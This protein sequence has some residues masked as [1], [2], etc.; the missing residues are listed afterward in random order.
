M[1]TEALLGRDPGELGYVTEHF[2]DL[3]GLLTAPILAGMLVAVALRQAAFV[4]IRHFPLVFATIAGLSVI[5]VL[6]IRLW[7]KRHYGVVASRRIQDCQESLLRS[8]PVQARQSSPW[9]VLILIALAALYL[10]PGLFSRDFHTPVGTGVAPFMLTLMI[11]PKCFYSIPDSGPIRL[12]RVFYIAGSSLILATACWGL[13]G[14]F[15]RWL[16]WYIDL[17]SV[18]FLSLY[19][20]WLLNR[21]LRGPS[22]RTANE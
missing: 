16:Y 7:Y 14:H 1:Q 3:R 15:S 5:C 19:D 18:L 9:G 2:G 8:R 22:A 13:F 11:L 4:A 6:W 17:G 20:H 12:R 21:L 10:G